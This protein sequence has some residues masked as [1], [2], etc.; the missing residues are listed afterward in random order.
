MVV[1][2][3]QGQ[4]G[5]QGRAGGRGGAGRGSRRSDVGGGKGAPLRLL[6]CRRWVELCG[7]VLCLLVD[8]FC[9]MN[10]W[11]GARGVMKAGG[12]RKQEGKSKGRVTRRMLAATAAT[13]SH[14]ALRGPR[15]RAIDLKAPKSRREI[16]GNRPRRL[17]GRGGR[18]REGRRIA[19]LLLLRPQ[20]PICCCCCWP[21]GCC[22][23]SSGSALCAP[24]THPTHSCSPAKAARSRRLLLL[25][26]VRRPLTSCER[27]LRVGGARRDLPWLDRPRGRSRR[28][29]CVP[30]A[31]HP[32]LHDWGCLTR[33]VI[34]GR[35][36]TA[37]PAPCRLLL[38]RSGEGLHNNAHRQ[39]HTRTFAPPRDPLPTM[40]REQEAEA[41]AA[42]ARRAGRRA[43]RW[44]LI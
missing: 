2:G 44:G 14:R 31:G 5:G 35:E 32:A 29:A 43:E 23:S 3:R 41:A 26:E 21:A 8:Y 19:L 13:G 10:E 6:V 24:H 22:G 11:K 28:L 4:G 34:P 1:G 37:T 12:A 36:V 20:K 17:G 33:S 15:H 42:G 16:G 25:F 30:L 18:G 40:M 7:K 27:H 9:G 39:T 38:E